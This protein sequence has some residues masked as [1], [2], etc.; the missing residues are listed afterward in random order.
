MSRNNKLE[1]Y[2]I[3]DALV[4]K[5][6]AAMIGIYGN[7]TFISD[8]R[9]KIIEDNWD[10]YT[11]VVREESEGVRVSYEVISEMLLE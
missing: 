5:L 2:K 7:H 3:S 4:K 10:L 1:Q 6:L 9:L 11:L 8:K